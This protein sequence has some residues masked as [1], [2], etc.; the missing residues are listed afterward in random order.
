MRSDDTI[1]F[2]RYRVDARRRQLLRDGKP[3]VL[4]GKAFDLLSIFVSSDGAVLTRDELYL[5][6]WP[7]SI[8]EDGNLSQ[9]VYL[10]RRALDPA[11]DGRGFIETMARVGYR[12][13]K[14]TRVVEPV[15]ERSVRS[16][17]YAIA[18]LFAILIGAAFS[19]FHPHGGTTPTAARDANTL[20]Q[21]H[22]DLRS[23]AHLGYALSYFEEEQR[24]TPAD[25][26]GF[27]GAAAAYA[28]LAEFQ[29]E[30]S[31]RQRALISLAKTGSESALRRDANSA[32]AVAVAGFIAYRFAAD[33]QVAERDFERA[34]AIDANDAQAHHWLGILFITQGKLDAGIAEIQTA[35]RLQPTSEV[36][37]R[38]LARAYVFTHQPDEAIAEARQTLRI[39]PADAPASLAIAAAQEQLGELGQALQTLLALQ[40]L[41]PSETPYVAPDAARLEVKLHRANRENLIRRV[42]RLAVTG[43]IDPFEAALFYLTVGRK[44]RAATLL[45]IA[46]RSNFAAGIQHNDPRLLALL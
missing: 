17:P 19:P 10:L 34:L 40:R 12:F 23:P 21:Y 7:A 28:L 18:A 9:T 37:S 1:A 13:A 25:P 41:V 26:A 20:G 45:R 16:L 5:R 24:L 30:G 11:G 2:D 29:T 33:R 4:S 39:A 14:E 36:Y 27:A 15:L 43:R 46:D 31:P 38:W 8:V 6:L 44:D 3:V 42:D 35:H 32:R 22:L